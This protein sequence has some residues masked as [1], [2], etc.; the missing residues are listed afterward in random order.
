[1]E[2]SNFSELASLLEKDVEAFKAR[3]SEAGYRVFINSQKFRSLREAVSGAQEA[4]DRLLEEFDNIGELDD[5]LASGAWQADF[6][7]DE[8]GSLDP[9]LPKDVLS[10]D[11]LYNLLEDIHQL[12]DD[13]AG[14]ARSIVYPSDENEQSQ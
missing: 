10:E 4:L 1:M 12:R 9:A 5:Y 13:M 7:A 3:Y 8:S 11:G 6:E 14:F 2:N